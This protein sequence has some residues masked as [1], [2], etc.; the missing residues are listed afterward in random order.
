[1]PGRLVAQDGR[2]GELVKAVDEVQVA[3]TH[4]AGDDAHHDLVVDGFVD[5]DLLDRQ[6]LMRAMENGGLHVWL[7]PAPSSRPAMVDQL[8]VDRAHHG[9]GDLNGLYSVLVRSPAWGGRIVA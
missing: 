4:A 1:M 2:R 9:S 6:R 3:V 7:P 8:A 5:V